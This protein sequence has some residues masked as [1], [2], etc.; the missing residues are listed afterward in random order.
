MRDRPGVPALGEHAD[1]DDVLDLLARLSILPDGVDLLPEIEGHL[2]LGAGP[3]LL[4]ALALG[5]GRG[6]VQRLGFLEHFRVDV[7]DPATVAEVIDADLSV[8]E[9]VGDSR[10]GLSGVRDGDHD[11]RG[12][13][14]GCNPF[15]LLLLPVEAEEVVGGVEEI[16]EGLGLF[17]ALAGEVVVDLRIRVEVVEAGPVV[18]GPRVGVVADDD[19]GGLDEARLDGVV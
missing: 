17:G 16:G 9:G 7:E 3:V 2:L 15:H 13:V 10:G 19:A 5:N 14:A 11:R 8:G 12:P 1:G 6:F 18:V 4:F